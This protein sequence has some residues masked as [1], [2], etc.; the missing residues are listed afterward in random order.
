MRR[1][2]SLQARLLALV[3]ALV[4]A[5]W[6]G[7]AAMTWREARH[8]LD[9]LLDAHLAQAAALLVV[10][11]AAEPDED[12][13]VDAPM[14]HRYAP[15]VAFQVWHEGRLHLRSANAPREPML[16]P[17]ADG[18]HDATIQGAAWRVFATSARE[19]EVR[20]LVGERQGSRGSILR[21][22]MKGTLQPMLLAFP[23]LALAVWWGV[24]RGLRPLRRMAGLLR[25]RSAA[26]LSRVDLPAAP[27]ELR[28]LVDA[29]NGLFERLA[30][31]M[32]SERRFTADAAHELR[33]PIAAIRTQAQVAWG[34]ADEVRRRA[35]LRA[36]LDGCDRA[37]RVVEQLLTLARLDA[38][39]ELPRGPVDLARVAREVLAEA[40]PLAQQR[41][42]AVGLE[43][44]PD[45]VVLHA[46][47]TLMKILLRNLVDNALRYS[48][49]GA[50][51]EVSLG[52]ENGA[53][54]LAV[55]DIGPGLSD[56]DLRRLGERFF[57][58]ATAAASG[59]GLGWSIASRIVQA[60]GGR[61]EA[62]NRDGGGLE[63]AC[64]L[65]APSAA[66]A[67]A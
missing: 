32:D 52:R 5:T 10:Q 12:H 49:G 11:Q 64:E 60:H 56:E 1:L 33:T 2:R 20:V 41:G 59:S 66:A 51:V 7:V 30:V 16:A 43:A 3:A 40:A 17:A 63:V 36:T 31:H 45:P 44:P 4:L 21:A 25:Q 18:F 24:A 29:L 38:E 26:D 46:N 19:G 65:P 47:E 9:E 6:S 50:E 53:L 8:E 55:R 58:G 57:R 54:R 37:T 13:G 42:Q 23:L 48:P 67:S 39:T 22:V 28:P 27:S 14:L 15:R 34:E 62:R 35:A 61:L